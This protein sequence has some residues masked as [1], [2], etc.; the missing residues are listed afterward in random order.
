MKIVQ[1]TFPSCNFL[2]NILQTKNIIPKASD[3]EIGLPLYRELWQ[4]LH[5]ALYRKDRPESVVFILRRVQETARNVR[6]RLSIDSSRVLNRLEEFSN[7]PFCDPLEL[8]DKTL[9]TLSAFSGLAMESMTRG[10]GWRFMDMGRRVERAMNLGDV[11]TYQSSR[12][13]Q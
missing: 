5:D 2:L 6:D 4:H 11:D 10:L 1:P 3:A 13:L 12:G 8:L 9:F 7:N